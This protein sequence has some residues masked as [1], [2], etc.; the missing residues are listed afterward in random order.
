MYFFKQKEKYPK[1]YHQI[2]SRIFPGWAV[3]NKQKQ[4]V[5][6]SNP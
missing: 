3:Y 1:L 6:E 2:E 5:G 4:F